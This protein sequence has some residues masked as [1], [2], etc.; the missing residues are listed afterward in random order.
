MW[1]PAWSLRIKKSSWGRWEADRQTHGL[2]HCHL[3]A[4]EAVSRF[5]FLFVCF[6]ISI[7][8]TLN[9]QLG[10]DPFNTSWVP[11][12][13]LTLRVTF[14]GLSNSSFFHWRIRHW[15][16]S[17]VHSV[18]LKEREHLGA[19][20]V[21]GGEGLCPVAGVWNAELWLKEMGL[22]YACSFLWLFRTPLNKW[23]LRDESEMLSWGHPLIKS[24][25]LQKGSKLSSTQARKQLSK[26]SAPWVTRP[27]SRSPVLDGAYSREHH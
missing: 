27:V 7:P 19:G 23:N 8:V 1:K 22:V 4:G 12:V 18:S 9:I 25:R 24:M 15:G 3:G 6:L 16:S 10:H 21:V 5:L 11:C 26:S 20:W 13:C 2:R 14:Y 17:A